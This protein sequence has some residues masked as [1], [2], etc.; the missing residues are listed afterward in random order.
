MGVAHVCYMNIDKVGKYSKMYYE[1]ITG[2]D[3]DSYRKGTKNLLRTQ[4]PL[5]LAN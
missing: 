2:I 4:T 3:I 5:C 1:N